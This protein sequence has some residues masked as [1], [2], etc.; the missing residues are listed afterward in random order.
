MTVQ[1]AAQEVKA[2]DA[3]EM[4]GVSSQTVFS[5]RSRLVKEGR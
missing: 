1:R 3:A 4:F 5:A 2:K